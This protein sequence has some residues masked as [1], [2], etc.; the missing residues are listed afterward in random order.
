MIV[1]L[2]T[3]KGER[4]EFKNSRGISLL[5]M[6][7][8]LYAGILMDSICRVIEGLVGN[9]QE[10]FRSWRRCLDKIFTLKQ[11]SKKVHGEKANCVCGF[12]GFREGI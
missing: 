9:E 10:G 3:G 11:V 7:G 2:Y 12:Q 5:S 1:S 8:K 6:V 4:T